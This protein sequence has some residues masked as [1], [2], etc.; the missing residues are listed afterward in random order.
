MPVTPGGGL[1]ARVVG[2]RLVRRYLGFDLPERDVR[3]AGVTEGMRVLEIGPGSGLYTRALLERVGAEG[4]V[5]GVDYSEQAAR[6]LAG[7]LEGARVVVGDAL[8]LPISAHAR[9]DAICS[10]YSL[11]EVPSAAEVAAS[12]SSLLADGGT[13]VLFLWRPLCGRKKRSSILD[14]LASA[15]LQVEAVW[16]DI[17]NVRVLLRKVSGGCLGVVG[18]A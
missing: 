17:Q 6:V 16:S 13:F 9:F 5:V 1:A 2:N 4:V 15:G 14:A 18:G 10:F 7:R 11:E 3:W 12:L 8:R